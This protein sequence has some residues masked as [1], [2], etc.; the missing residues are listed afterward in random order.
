MLTLQYSGPFNPEA[1]FTLLSMG[2]ADPCLRVEP[3]GRVR[4]AMQTCDGPAAADM[5]IKAGTVEAS[6]RGEAGEQLLPELSDVLG[7]WFEPPQ[8]DHPS[9]LRRIAKKYEGMRIPRLPAISLRLVQI[10]LQQLIS[11]RDA[12]YGWRQL[13]LKHGCR[14]AGDDDLW[15]PPSPDVIRKLASYQF[16][17]CGIPPKHG[18]RIVEAMRFSK[19]LE[20]LWADGRDADC[21]DRVCELL[22]KIP[23]IGPWTIGFLRAA[24]LGDADAEILGDYGH[25]KHVSYFFTGSADG[26]DAEMLRLLEPYRPY[27]SYVLCL[28]IK[29]APTPPRRGPKRRS[30]RDQYGF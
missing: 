17:E 20:S 6:C 2:P 26:D 29:G 8:I 10:I 28:L 5:Q 9:K 1:T 22:A 16:I 27:R 23:G 11:Y 19:R 4:L 3:T 15:Y 13:V 18:R 24:G 14:V 21:A 12:C 30:L 25:P 7:L